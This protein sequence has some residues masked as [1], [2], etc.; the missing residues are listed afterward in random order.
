MSTEAPGLSRE[1]HEDLRYV[2]GLAPEG[3]PYALDL[4]DERQHRYFMSRIRRSG[5]SEATHPRLFGAL[6]E[7]AEAHRANGGPARAGAAAAL[8][9]PGLVDENLIT[10]FGLTATEQN[11][12]STAMSS[13]ENGT[14]FTTLSLE[15]LDEA[16]SAVLGSTF[17]PTVYG[18]GEY[19]PLSLTG[20]L[21]NTGAGMQAVFNFAYQTQPDEPPV[22]GFVQF[23][24]AERPVGPPTVTQ[25]VRR[26]THLANPV[27]KIGLGRDPA[28]TP[29]ADLDYYYL[30]PNINDPNIRLPMVGSQKFASNIVTPLFNPDGSQANI[31]VAIVM[32]RETGGGT[33]PLPVIN[34][35]LQNYFQV[36]ATDPTVLTWSFPWNAQLNLDKSMQFGPAAW[37]QD[38]NLLL[39]FFVGVRTATSPLRFVRTWVYSATT[40]PY[41]PDVGPGSDGMYRLRP[42]WYTWHCVAEGTQVTLAD[43]TTADVARVVGGERVRTD[44]QGAEFTVVDTFVSAKEGEVVAL[45]TEHGHELLITPM[46]GVVTR[47]GYVPAQD[48]VPGD[49]LTTDRGE[50]VLESVE[51]RAYSGMVYSLGLGATEEEVASFT[52]DNTNFFANG[53]LVADNRLSIQFRRSYTRRLDAVLR[54]LPPEWHEEARQNYP[55]QAARQKHAGVPELSSLAPPRAASVAG[56]RG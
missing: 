48:L 10:S 47:D 27:I 52:D 45:R 51:R 17:P 26:P 19:E 24:T 56:A 15:I 16:T 9:E 46:H 44:A 6:N 25:P 32:A 54:R 4:S 43:G 41:N 12:V 13:V 53:I 22:V 36:S 31:T 42:V 39:S 40:G 14:L 5:A 11:S 35:N 21:P 18:E 50:S 20:A 34:T 2:I 28:H 33:K 29:V 7:L 8:A 49:V 37:A 3:Q 1:E 30:E 23:S 55:M 38:S